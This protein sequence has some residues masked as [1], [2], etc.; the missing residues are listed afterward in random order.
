MCHY[1]SKSC[2]HGAWRPC[3][4]VSAGSAAPRSSRVPRTA[5]SAPPTWSTSPDTSPEKSVGSLR[6]APHS[7]EAVSGLSVPVFSATVA[8]K[9]VFALYFFSAP[10]PRR[11]GLQAILGPFTRHS[12]HSGRERPVPAT[13]VW[14]SAWACW[15]FSSVRRHR[16]VVPLRCLAPAS[17]IG[18][19]ARRSD[20]IEQPHMPPCA[21]LATPLL[22]TG[23]SCEVGISHN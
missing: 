2:N 14:S 10:K 7:A 5:R 1:A 16:P 12:G 4:A 22:R 13:T 23:S 21:A 11:E 15:V 9:A 6:P 18:E 8:R 3:S 20:A 17:K 19:A